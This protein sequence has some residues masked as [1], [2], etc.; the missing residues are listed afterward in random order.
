MINGYNSQNLKLSC[1]DKIFKTV[2]YICVHCSRIT[3]ESPAVENSCPQKQI[4]STWK[5]CVYTAII[6]C[7]FMI[8]VC[9]GRNTSEVRLLFL[10]KNVFSF[11]HEIVCIYFL[12]I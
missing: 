10:A 4:E 9:S 1:F 5:S 6:R 12:M 2:T 8:N 3:V 7:H 11:K